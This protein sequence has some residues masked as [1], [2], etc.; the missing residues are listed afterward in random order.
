MNM[1]TSQHGHSFSLGI[2]ELTSLGMFVGS[3]GYSKY[4][5]FRETQLHLPELLR[6]FCSRNTGKRNRTRVIICHGNVINTVLWDGQSSTCITEFDD[7][8]PDLGS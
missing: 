4:C 3:T 2:L 7:V 8:S 5:Y 6:M 1:Y